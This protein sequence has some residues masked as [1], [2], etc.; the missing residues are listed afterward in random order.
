MRNQSNNSND[1]YTHVNSSLPESNFFEYLSP[2]SSTY[3]ASCIAEAAHLRPFTAFLLLQAAPLPRMLSNYFVLAGTNF[4][5]D[6]YALNVEDPIWGADWKE[7]RPERWHELEWRDEKGG[8]GTRYILASWFR[9]KTM[10]GKVC[11]GFG[12]EAGHGGNLGGL[13]GDWNWRRHLKGRRI[14]GVGMPRRGYI[15]RLCI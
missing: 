3:L 8:S 2:Q 1:N 13:A 14:C 9:T 15:I 7:F 6:A 4:I 5:V 12:L 11:C 10:N